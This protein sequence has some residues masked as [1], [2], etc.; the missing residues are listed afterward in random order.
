M[1]ADPEINVVVFEVQLGGQLQQLVG[2]G[3]TRATDCVKTAWLA[4]SAQCRASAAN[5]CRVYSEW[6]P[7]PHDKAFI[8]ATFPSEVQFTYSFARPTPDGWD[9]AMQ[10]VA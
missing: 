2:D 1:N 4:V 9:R 8:E 3:P 10:E 6:E 5:V 7:S